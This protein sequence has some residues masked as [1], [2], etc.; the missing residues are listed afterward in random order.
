MLGGREYQTV[1]TEY[2]ASDSAPWDTVE[3]VDAVNWFTSTIL[4]AGFGRLLGKKADS[5]ASADNGTMHGDGG[6]NAA[7][8][9]KR[10]KNGDAI[11][12]PM[13]D[14]SA[15]SWDVVRFRYW[16][17]RASASSG[18]F[19]R[20][21]LARMK[22]GKAPLDFNSR[23]G[24]FESRELHHVNPQR[25]GGSNGPLN[26]RELTPDQHGAVDPF[27]HTVPTT[28]GIR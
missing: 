16:K 13:A 22:Q 1:S 2:D 6:G 14:G 7:V 17:A 19:S 21:N 26:I 20:D 9:F 24:K 15:P 8:K 25:A 12:K 28:S 5:N 10:W 3:K 18:E 11:D 23:T 27:R 4:G